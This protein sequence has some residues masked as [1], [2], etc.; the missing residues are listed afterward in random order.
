[1]KRDPRLELAYQVIPKVIHI[2]RDCSLVDKRCHFYIQFAAKVRNRANGAYLALHRTVR[3]VVVANGAILRLHQ[4][5]RFAPIVRDKFARA[6]IHY[7]PILRS[8]FIVRK[9]L[10]Y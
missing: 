10:A 1:M 6:Q 2:A 7:F 4:T 5:V 8:R 3:L 9:L